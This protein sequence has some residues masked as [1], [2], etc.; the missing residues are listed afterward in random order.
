MKVYAAL[1]NPMIEE[2][3]WSTLSLHKTLKGA[4]K[5]RDTHKAKAREEWKKLD[6]WQRKEFGDKYEE[7]KTSPFG[8]W[9][10][11]DVEEIE[12]LD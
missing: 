6:D 5:A 11:W 8:I 10:K 7:L 2:S 9:Q 3:A 1:Y 12:V 4:V